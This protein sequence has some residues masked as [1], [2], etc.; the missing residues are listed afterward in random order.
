[1]SRPECTSLPSPSYTSSDRLRR[2]PSAAPEG[3]DA[4]VVLVPIG[5]MLL[6]D[7]R[8]SEEWK[9]LVAKARGQVMEVMEGR[10]GLGKGELD[11]MIVWEDVNTPVTCG[12][13]LISLG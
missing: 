13:S 5:H 9:G 8:T 1:M 6:A 12:S 3:K 4:L 10:L 2:D 7:N 11:K